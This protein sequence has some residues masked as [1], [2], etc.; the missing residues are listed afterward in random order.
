[1]LG[2]HN[3]SV[4]QLPPKIFRISHIAE[5]EGNLHIGKLFKYIQL[6]CSVIAILKGQSAAVVQWFQ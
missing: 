6:A 4:L 2:I 1:M 5:T 3:V